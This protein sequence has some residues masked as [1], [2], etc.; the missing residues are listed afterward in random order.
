[1]VD[2]MGSGWGSI[3]INI[4]SGKATAKGEAAG[5]YDIAKEIA[6][7]ASVASVSKNLT[8]ELIAIVKEA[9]SGV[10]K[11]ARTI[12]VGTLK[13]VAQLLRPIT[14]MVVLILMPI[15]QFIRPIIKVFNDVMR[16]FRNAAYQLMRAAGKETDPLKKGALQ[17]LSAYSI[18]TGF[19]LALQ[20][21]TAEILKFILGIVAQ[22]IGKI[23][24]AIR[25]EE[26]GKELAATITNSING[27]IDT[28]TGA[29]QTTAL[30]GIKSLADGLGVT[31]N[32]NLQSGINKAFGN[33][34]IPEIFGPQNPNANV[35]NATSI[36]TSTNISNTST[37]LTSSYLQFQ[38]S[39][40]GFSQDPTRRL[41]KVNNA[42]TGTSTFYGGG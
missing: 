35:N 2:G 14:D 7:V 10:L 41:L 16:P 27:W 37:L 9:V 36:K 12:I 33:L 8:E 13:L 29:V 34:K 40:E 1:M 25:G 42:Y 11:P 24:G 30:D 38:S 22:L 19:A 4:L 3:D 21:V 39:A 18:M 26:K 20:A 31:L 17:T 15:L 6:K 23:W 28:A 32:N 5:K